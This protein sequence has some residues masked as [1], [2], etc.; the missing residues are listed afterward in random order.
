MPRAQLAAENLFL[1]RQLALYQERHVKP[2]RPDPSTRVVLVLL[3]HLLEWR[4]LLTVVQRE[5][6]R[7]IAKPILGGLHHE[8]CLAQEAA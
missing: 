3:S 5:H 4:S 6:S 1:R 2:R 8:Y 7:V